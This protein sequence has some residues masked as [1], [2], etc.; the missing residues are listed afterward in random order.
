VAID[1]NRYFGS[2]LIRQRM[3]IKD[4]GWLTSYGHFSQELLDQDVQSILDLYRSNGFEQVKVNAAIQDDLNGVAG[5]MEVDI[6]IDEGPQTR[7]ASLEIQG[8]EKVKPEELLPLLTTAEGQ[9]YSSSNVATD[10]DLITNYYFNRGFSQISF[11]ASATPDP[12]DPQRMH[13][14]YRVQE[15]EQVF[16]DRIFMSG[17][18]NTKPGIAKRQFQFKSGDPL[19]QTAMLE[20]QRR[21]YDLGVFNEVKLAVQNRDGEAKY[22]NILLQFT[23][24]RRWTFNYGVGMEIQSG[25]FG[26]RTNP[27]GETGASPTVSFD[28]SRLNVGGRAHTFSFKSHLGRLQ[29]Q[30]LATY[31]APRLLNHQDLRL[32]FNLLYDNS[33]NVRTFTS[34]RMEGSIQLEQVLSRVSTL[35]YRFT[36]R[37]VQASE[38]QIDPAAIPLLSRPV[39]V[40][41]PSISYIRDKRDDP[42]ES[43]NGNYSTLDAGVA[44]SV[45]GSEADFG[46]LLV[47]NSTYHPFHSGQWVF[48]RYTQIGIAKP[49]GSVSGDP[50]AEPVIPLPERFFAG[51]ANGLRGF[52]LNQAGPRDL[53]TGQVLG[54]EAVFV[55]SL[56]LRTPPLDLPY[57]GDN[58]SFAFFHDAGNVFSTV[59]DMG[60]GLVQWVQKDR[61]SC[62]NEATASQC[63]F[64][65]LSHA[66]GLGIRYRTPIGPVRLDVG[67][68]LN[69]TTYSFYDDPSGTPPAGFHSARTGRVQFSFSIGQ[70]F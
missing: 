20:T 9:P 2:D 23:E 31:E 65:Y 6:K 32:T 55:N 43:H 53:L 29:Q 27:N 52:A 1:G 48:A 22:K 7:V 46:R 54:G 44:S 64:A 13:V 15:G 62:T 66:L 8:A 39:R 47:Q 17:L 40:G 24:A 70:T 63:N 50:T 19:S 28:L 57:L 38:L 58:L 26:A 37:R 36:Y 35:L 30:A 69:P 60:R 42:I 5:R 67:Y 59:G 10:R 61:E 45:F 49:F 11:A 51:G 25:V 12:A 21:L 18:D 41:L 14:V 34:Q 4:A 68:N 16:V 3:Q 33:L 56:E